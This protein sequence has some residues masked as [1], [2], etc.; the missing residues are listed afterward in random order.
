MNLGNKQP[1]K[2]FGQIQSCQNYLKIEDEKNLKQ[3]KKLVFNKHFVA[4]EEYCTVT[5]NV[6]D[7]D[8]C[9]YENGGGNYIYYFHLLLD[10]LIGRIMLDPNATTNGFK[11]QV[12]LKR[13]RDFPVIIPSNEVLNAGISLDLSIK[14]IIDIARKDN[15]EQ[16]IESAKNLMEELRDDFVMELY[17]KDFFISHDITIIEP[18]VDIVKSCE[19][20]H[21]HDIV[22][23][24]MRAITDPEGNLL[25][26]MRRFRV[27]MSNFNLKSS[28]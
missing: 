19:G 13:L 5:R 15:D 25:S 21:F 3:Q 24:I 10:S 16:F 8:V 1:L 18:L 26:N 7:G 11:G 17:I 6:N 2:D 23:H 28:L 4:S 27:L 20:M 14:T 9:F 22:I 12:T